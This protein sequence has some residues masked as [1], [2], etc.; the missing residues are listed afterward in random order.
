MAIGS[1]LSCLGD[2]TLLTFKVGK[3]NQLKTSAPPEYSDQK[4]PSDP[5]LVSTAAVLLDA[6]LH[7]SAYEID[8]QQCAALVITTERLSKVYVLY[9]TFLV[10]P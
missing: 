8:I 10:V 9:N 6:R 2:R 3:H 1:L 4:S 5:R 7:R